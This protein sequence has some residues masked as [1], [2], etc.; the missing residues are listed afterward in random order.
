MDYFPRR[1]KSKN[2]L[3]NYCYYNE[4]N[5]YYNDYNDHNEYK[6]RNII[7]DLEIQEKKLIIDLEKKQKKNAN[8]ILMHNNII[9]TKIRP[10]ICRFNQIIIPDLTNIILN[11]LGLNIINGFLIGNL[12]LKPVKSCTHLCDCAYTTKCC[13][14]SDVR[15]NQNIF[16]YVDGKGIING[17]KNEYYCPT[18]KDGATYCELNTIYI[19]YNQ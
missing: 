3:I 1:L 4:K 9:N 2:E 5:G 15:N 8:C 11:Y 19:I 14:C 7:Y 6:A 10:L 17:I 13:Y 18:C 16:K 12:K